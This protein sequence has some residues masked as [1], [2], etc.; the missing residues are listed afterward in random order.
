MTEIDTEPIIR[1]RVSE[2]MKLKGTRGS[3]RSLESGLAVDGRG[4]D[5]AAEQKR[6]AIVVPDDVEVGSGGNEGNGSA[7]VQV[8]GRVVVREVGGKEVESSGLGVKF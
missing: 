1:L 8:M 5:D 4:Y 3:V 6:Y 2:P 7:R